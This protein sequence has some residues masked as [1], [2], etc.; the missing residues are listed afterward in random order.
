MY[1]VN[2]TLASVLLH[3]LLLHS[4]ASVTLFPCSEAVGNELSL[5]LLLL[6][7]ILPA[8]LEQSHTRAWLKLLV[9][10]W[11]IAVSKLLGLRSYLLGDV[12]L[13]ENVS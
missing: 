4:S 11:C 9:K 3:T 6:Q 13:D 5:E 8:L 2:F 7:V 12:I 1:V 10:H